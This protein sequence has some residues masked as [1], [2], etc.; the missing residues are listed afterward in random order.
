MLNNNINKELEKAVYEKNL[1]EVK[2]LLSAGADINLRVEHNR[3][4]LLHYASS[5]E[6]TKELLLRGAEVNARNMYSETPLHSAIT[7][8]KKL[9]LVRELLKHGADVNATNRKGNTALNHAV[10]KSDKNLEVIKELLE[11]GADINIRNRERRLFDNHNT[12]LDNAMSYPE[13]AKLLIKFTLIKNFSK[14]YKQIINLTPYK[15]FNTYSELSRYFDDCICEILQMKTDKIKNDLSL[16]ELVTNNFN[17]HVLY[18]NQLSV[19]L[20][21]IGY[22][23]HYPIY[24]DIILDKI[25]PFLERADL[26]NKLNKVQV[27]TKLDILNQDIKGKKVILDSDSTCNIIEYLSNDDL[28]NLIAAFNDSDKC[29][30]RSL[31]SLN[32]LV[33]PN[34]RLHEASTSNYAKRARLE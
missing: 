17:K 26:L 16:Y 21:K 11:Y 5:V 32:N 34:T 15:T 29:A 3:D 12:P 31:S 24:N 14:D 22:S 30:I 8:G 25:K 33:E 18:D 7:F 9:E 13:C 28:L 1:E 6:I 27:Y 10:K 19:K 20:T 4:T 23:V 2:A